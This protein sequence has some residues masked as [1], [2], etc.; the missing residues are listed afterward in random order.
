MP[1]RG[2]RTSRRELMRLAGAL[3]VASFARPVVAAG[4]L[5][6][7]PRFLDDP[8]KLGVASGDPISDGV[9]LWTRLAPD[10]FEPAAM[11]PVPVVVDWEIAADEG[12]RKTVRKGRAIAHPDSAFAVHVDV[13]GLAPDRD[14][15]YRFRAGD[16]E[17]PVG[18]TH[19]AP[20]PGATIDR[21]R[22]A[23]G[24]CQQYEMGY[25]GAYRDMVAQSPDL[26]IHL[27][28]YIYEKPWDGGVR[29]HP[30]TE[31]Y[32]LED[33]RAYHALYKLDPDLQAAHRAAPWLVTWDDHEVD[34]D[35]AGL[36][37]EDYEDPAAFLKR[38]TAAY[39]AYFEHMPLRRI[40]TPHDGQMSLYQS[41]RYGDLLTFFV[42][43]GRQYR[44]PEA[45]RLLDN[46]HGRVV[47]QSEC[48]ALADPSRSLLGFD[49]ESWLY[50]GLRK[51]ETRW[52]VI[53]QQLLFAPFDQGKG[54]D[55]GVYTDSWGGYQANRNRI[56]ETI[57]TRRPS[58]PV[59]I[60]G[61]IHSYWVT[62]I[63]RDPTDPDSETVAT[64]FVG[65]SVTSPLDIYPAFEAALPRNPHVRY[66][67]GARRG[68]CLVTVTPKAMRADLRSVIDVTR[69]DTASETLASFVVEDGRPGAVKA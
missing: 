49:Q 38:R 59:F 4:L 5:D 21:L 34:N 42:L 47:N 67:E 10:P 36:T 53:A 62:D 28:D 69:P 37:S 24:S 9:V 66:F 50:R 65:S 39:R 51:T 13:R 27:G 18:R 16:A 29:R 17:S 40:A 14:Y 15:F 45:C 3:A 56:I 33:Y 55:R 25:Y 48:R 11:E 43:D 6:R 32:T 60:G 44:S 20:L 64:E 63:K 22:F 61:D 68:Y 52:N 7:K 35:Y 2:P 1:I 57:A 19:T 58:N 30:W 54:P 31:A 26:V 12:M 23:F 46:G 8:F 41:V